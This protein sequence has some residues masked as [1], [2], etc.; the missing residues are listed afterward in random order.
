VAEGDYYTVEQAARILKRTPGRIRQM[1]RAGNLK[2]DHDEAGQ[3][4]IPQHAVHDRPRPPRVTREPSTDPAAAGLSSPN[5]D[6]ETK[7]QELQ[8][9][10][11]RALGRLELTEVAESTLRESLDRARQRAD[12]LE[13]ETRQLRSQLEEARKPWWRKLFGNQ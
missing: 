6:L 13:L 5:E 7:V 2:G 9:E 12:A 4:R 10:L 8:F 1:L 3:W 11:G